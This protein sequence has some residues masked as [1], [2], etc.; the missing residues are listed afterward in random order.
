MLRLRPTCQALL[1][2]SNW[3]SGICLLKQQEYQTI[4][5]QLNAT[6]GPSEFRFFSS[7]LI[8]TNENK[9]HHTTTTQQQQQQPLFSLE[10]LDKVKEEL[11]QLL[12]TETN[13]P[14]P[15]PGKTSGDASVDEATRQW[16]LANT[17]DDPNLQKIYKSTKQPTTKA[18]TNLMKQQQQPRD[19]DDDEFQIGVDQED[20]SKYVNPFN[21]ETQEVNGPKGEEPTRF[22][23]WERNGRCVDF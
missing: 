3:K 16:R 22:G 23:D 7:S 18:T 1:K 10:D 4:V 15:S 2:R 9:N 6:R 21:P 5:Q 8:I 14:L 11:V 17:K 20:F 13:V 12:M 19:E